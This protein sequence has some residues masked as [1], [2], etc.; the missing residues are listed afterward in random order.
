VQAKGREQQLQEE[1]HR[2]DEAEGDESNKV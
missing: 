1:A 2:L